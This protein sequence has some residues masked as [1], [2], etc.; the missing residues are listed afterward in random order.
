MTGDAKAD[1]ARETESGT[2]RQLRLMRW[3]ALHA[4]AALN[5][6]LIWSIALVYAVDTSRPSTRASRIYLQRVLK[7]A[8]GLRERHIHARTFAHVFF[9]RVKFL[10]NGPDG[11]RIDAQGQQLIERQ[12]RTGR[13]GV[14]LGA[15]F[16]SFEALRAFDGTLPGLRVRYLMFPEHAPASTALLNELNVETASRVIPLTNSLQAMLEVHDAL[17]KGEFVAFLGDRQPGRSTR[18]QLAVPFLGDSINLPTSP[19]IAAITARVPLFLCIAPRLGKNHYAIEF[20]ELYDGSTVPRAERKSRI[21]ALTSTYAR[22]LERLC[23]RYPYNWF[24]FYD[25]W[26][27][28][29]SVPGTGAG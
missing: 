19:Y 16:G 15:H 17:T 9:D 12:Y 24:N 2:A 4:P 23:N 8:P 14:L 5:N 1:W 10:S 25:I 28:P 27:E 13:G 22:H 26:S 21:A 3:L 29:G 6:A 18:S 7:K 11:F 20:H